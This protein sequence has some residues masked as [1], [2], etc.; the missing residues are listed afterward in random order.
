MKAMCYTEYGSPEVL[1]LAQIPKPVPRKNEVLVR[2]HATSVTIGDT[3]MRSLNIP[4]PHIQKIMARLYLGWNKP[5]RPVLGMELAG[6]VESIGATVTRFKPGDEVFASTFAVGF[7]AYAEYI[8]LPETG[9]LALRPR[10]LTAAEAA[11]APGAGM[12]ALACL[13]KA[14]IHPG[15]KVVV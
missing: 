12:T 9:V 11:V 14:R 8:C 6:V 4:V 1:N 5:K 7:G 15:Q 13:K 2:I 3:V 10:N